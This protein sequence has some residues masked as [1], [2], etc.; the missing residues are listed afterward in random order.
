MLFVFPVFY[1]Y[2]YNYKSLKLDLGR[3]QYIGH[4]VF[5]SHAGF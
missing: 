5:R 3:V 4:T 1:S 2:T